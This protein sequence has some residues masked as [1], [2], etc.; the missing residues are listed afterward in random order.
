MIRAALLLLTG[1][2]TLAAA[3]EPMLPIPPIPPTHPPTDTA[4]PVPDD[5]MRAPVT[6]ADATTQVKLQLYR[7]HRYDGSRGFL[8]G[9][10][11]ESTEDRRPIQTPGLSVSVPLR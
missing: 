6:V 10:R 5:D 9:S 11:Y 2:L 1:L 3:P 4:A 7:V 8:P